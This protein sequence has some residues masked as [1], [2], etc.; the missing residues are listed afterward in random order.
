MQGVRALGTTGD[1]THTGHSQGRLVG[2]RVLGGSGAGGSG[3]RDNRGASRDAEAW[4][5]S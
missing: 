2:I 5:S 3:A 4:K 1:K